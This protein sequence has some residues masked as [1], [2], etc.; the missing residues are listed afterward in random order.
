MFEIYLGIYFYF[1]EALLI[2][3]GIPLNLLKFSLKRFAKSSACA[4]YFS[5]LGQVFSGVKISSG[6]PGQERGTLNPKIGSIRVGN[7][8]R[9]PSKAALIIA[10]VC[11]ILNLLPTP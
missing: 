6:T 5:G 2:S 3:D 9:E 4:W 7:A 10:R 8:S 1:G 11:G